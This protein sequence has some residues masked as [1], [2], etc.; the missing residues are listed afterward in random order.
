VERDIRKSYNS[1]KAREQT[2]MSMAKMTSHL[3]YLD[4]LKRSY[5]VKRVPQ[6]IRKASV[7]VTSTEKKNREITGSSSVDVRK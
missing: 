5:D 7:D 6:N 2:K 3:A 1:Q 4:P